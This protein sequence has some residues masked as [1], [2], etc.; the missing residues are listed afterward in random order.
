MDIKKANNLFSD[1][2]QVT[3]VVLEESKTVLYDTNDSKGLSLT[4]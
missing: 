2:R 3:E 4:F 1:L